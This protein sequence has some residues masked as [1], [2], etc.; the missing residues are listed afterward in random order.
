MLPSL[1]ACRL[2]SSQPRQ[3][4]TLTG[5]RCCFPAVFFLFAI[6]VGGMAVISSYNAAER[7]ATLETSLTALPQTGD[8]YAITPTPARVLQVSTTPGPRVV[9]CASATY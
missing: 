8:G 1:A 4:T 3:P 7:L 2:N 6:Q 5:L 9:C